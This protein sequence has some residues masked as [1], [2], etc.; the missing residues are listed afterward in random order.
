MKKT[1]INGKR[2]IALGDLDH[3]RYN[4][5]KDIYDRYER[6]E[7]GKIHLSDTD[8]ARI[9]AYHRIMAEVM[10]V[11]IAAAET[12]DEIREMHDEM[13]KEWMR[14]KYVIVGNDNGQN[15]FF[16]K[17]CGAMNDDGDE[18]PVFCSKIRLA[19]T[20]DD[21]FAATT[22]ALYLKQDYDLEV[23]VEPLYLYAM[24]NNDAK[25]LLDAIFKKDDS[26]SSTGD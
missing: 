17:M 14:D 11:E 19:N 24:T 25:K 4:L 18:Q 21:H 1:V 23:K 12:P 13:R 9:D 10:A 7:D 6:G 5:C 20:Y 8:M 16:R 3:L 26:E 15:V 22:M 2:Y